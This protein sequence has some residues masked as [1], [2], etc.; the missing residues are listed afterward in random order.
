MHFAGE[1]FDFYD[2]GFSLLEFELAGLESEITPLDDQRL[3]ARRECDFFLVGF[4]QD[5]VAPFDDHLHFRIVDLHTQRS[6]GCL[7]E[8]DDGPQQRQDSQQA[9]ATSD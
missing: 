5:N 8:E 4:A 3:L 9:S 7:E 6:V 2:R 1:Q